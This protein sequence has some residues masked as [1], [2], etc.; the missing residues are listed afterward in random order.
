MISNLQT[1][2]KGQERRSYL[3]RSLLG[4]TLLN[5]WVRHPLG[6]RPSHLSDFTSLQR[7]PVKSPS[8]IGRQGNF[9]QLG[10]DFIFGPGMHLYSLDRNKSLNLASKL[11][12]ACSYLS[13]MRHTEDR[14]FCVL[15]ELYDLFLLSVIIVD[16]EVAELMKA[17]S[18]TYP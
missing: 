13:R 4:S 18:V 10:G 9:S 1:T 14:A 16:V 5:I 12:I 11:G 7:G 6:M 15:T 17:A 2:P 8:H 3:K